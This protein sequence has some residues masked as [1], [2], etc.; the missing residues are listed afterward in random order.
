MKMSKTSGKT[1]TGRMLLALTIVGSTAVIIAPAISSILRKNAGSHFHNGFHRFLMDTDSDIEEQEI[2][3]DESSFLFRPVFPMRPV[4]YV[5]FLATIL[6]LIMA[7]GG[8]IGGGGFLV[9]IYILIMGFPVKHAVCLSNVTVLG[10]AIANL[11]LNFSKRHPSSVINRPLIDWNL[12]AMMEPLTMAGALL[13]ADL[14]EYLPDVVLVT[15][16]VLLLGFTSFRTLKKVRKYYQHAWNL[17]NLSK[18]QCLLCKANQMHAVESN[19]G[20]TITTDIAAKEDEEALIAPVV[21]SQGSSLSSS[22]SSSARSLSYGTQGDSCSGSM[23]ETPSL[24]KEL[25]RFLEK[26]SHVPWVRIAELVGLFLAVV[27][28][29][30]VKGSGDKLEW[31]LPFEVTCGSPGYNWLGKIN[32]VLILAFALYIRQELIR[33]TA[34]KQALHYEFVPGDIQWNS[35]NTLLYSSICSTAGLFAGLFGIGKR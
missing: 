20:K 1:T 27:V 19:N 7:A 32:L 23:V 11:L 8:G 31:L 26:E 24:S 14:N 9:P 22:S 18:F 15:L 2:I 33:D 13:G 30:L 10:G 17:L 12:M 29:N 35:R 25:A 6:G 28:L 3:S 34:H 21:E 5:G 16:L 4:D